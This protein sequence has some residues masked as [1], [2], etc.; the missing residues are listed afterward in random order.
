MTP[1][2]MV[3]EIQDFGFT[4][5]ASA[6]MY[7][8]LNQALKEITNKRPWP[9]R[10]TTTTLTFDGTNPNPSNATFN[11]RSVIALTNPSNGYV[12]LPITRQEFQKAYAQN[13]S[14]TGDPIMY[15]FDGPTL[16][17][18]KIPG[19]STTLT[20][21][22]LSFQTDV[23]STSVESDVLLPDEYHWLPI[24]LTLSRL[25]FKDD[26]LEMAKWAR[27]EA[28]RLEALMTQDMWMRTQ[29][30]RPMTIQL[31]DEANYEDYN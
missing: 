27:D 4:D 16:K 23:S 17:V 22:Y 30:D 15:Y 6:R 21:N 14:D 3:T 29:Y 7:A 2:E 13:L 19:A 24:F 9:W 26:D 31:V 28:E 20:C 11:V 25:F 18:Y 10:E 8:L 5:T 1:A 12:L